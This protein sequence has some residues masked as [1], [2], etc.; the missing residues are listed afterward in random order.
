M[1]QLS[2]P[3]RAGSAFWMLASFCIMC[4]H[5]RRRFQTHAW[6]AVTPIHPACRSKAMSDCLRHPQRLHASY[7]NK[8]N[9]EGEEDDDDDDEPPEVD[10]AKFSPPSMSI[11]V[12]LNRGRS[13][14]SIRKAMGTSKAGMTKV[15][16]CTNCGGE[17][18]QWMGRCPTCREWNTLQEMTVTRQA[19]S[20]PPRPVFGGSGGLSSSGNN[21]FARASPS[22]WLDGIGA[23]DPQDFMAPVRVTEVLR[24]EANPGRKR[25]RI[26][27]PNDDEINQVLGGGI[28][29]GSLILLGGDP[30]VGNSTL[31]LQMAASVATLSTPTPGIGMGLPSESSTTGN[32]E[33]GLDIGPVWYVSGEETLEQIASRAQRLGSTSSELY[34]VTETNVNVLAN[35]VLQ[36][37]SPLPAIDTD[38]STNSGVPPKPPS[39]LVVDSIQTMFCDTAVGSAGGVAQVRECVALLLR[40]AKSTGIPIFLV[41]HVT[42]SGDVAGPR[43]VEHMVD[44]V[45]YLEGAEDPSSTLSNLR[46]LRASKNRFGSSTEIGMYEMTRDCFMP[47][48]DP[49]SRLLQDRISSTR[50]LVGCA[51]ALVVEGLRPMTLP[52]QALCT[53]SSLPNGKRTVHGIGYS[54]LQLLLGVLQKH[55]HIFLSK[56]DV[57]INLVGQVKETCHASDLAVVVALVSSWASTP[58]RA[59]TAFCGQVG[60]LGELRQ[61][62]ALDQRLLEASRMGFSRV[63]T[64]VSGG[65]GGGGGKG[66]MSKHSKHGA[67]KLQQDQRATRIHGMEWIQCENVMEAISVGLV[68][69][70]PTSSVR[71][72]RSAASMPTTSSNNVPAAPGTIE[73]LNLDREGPGGIILDDDD[74]DDEDYL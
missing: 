13:S 40:L 15:F 68:A 45:L 1:R 64:A 20:H 52:V 44:T 63:V 17:S 29:K 16:V 30:G 10:T 60:L 6:V 42:K 46:I 25:S 9:E 26:S 21:R 53:S 18:V 71:R 48:S 28:M 39:L 8:P 12:G 69:P 57:Y 38:C 72:K 27:V 70:I 74:D 37:V 41:G 19:S 3:L 61:V 43:T 47:I 11:Q 50:D 36:L 59:D 32:D 73:D 31:L 2:F 51:V 67:K 35:Q 65:W 49:S 14:P 62:P 22:S 58:V 54:R 55:G 34:L 4:A 24:D 33:S 23:Y 66:V 5:P 7:P 56:Q